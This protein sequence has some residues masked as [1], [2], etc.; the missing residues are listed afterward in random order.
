MTPETVL[1][2]V[3][4]FRRPAWAGEL[5]TA[6]GEQA[7][8]VQAGADPHGGAS[9]RVVVLDNDPDGSAREAVAEHPLVRSGAASYVHV[10]AKDVVSV[11]NAALDLARA[12]GVAVL[13]FIDDDEMPEPGWLAAFLRHRAE[14]G[15]DVIAGPVRQE[16]MV[17]EIPVAQALLQRAERARGPFTGD[18]GT[19]NV[20][21]SMDLVRRADLSFDS[22]TGRSGGE[23]TLFFRQAARAGARF[24]WEPKAAVIERSQPGRLTTRALLRR[25]YLNG[26]SSVLVDEALDGAPSRPRRLAT[27][28]AAA[29]VYLPLAAAR[30]VTGDRVAGWRLAHKVM[31][32]VGRAR[33]GRSSVGDYGG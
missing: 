26:R 32:H 12:E 21:I 3:P 33:A 4:T 6:L 18:V 10:G 31:R 8:S 13:V 16:P 22:I 29:G 2:A 9:V 14:L 30:A 7:S 23:D 27:A 28:V 20:L 15:A 11:R 19:G 24:S 25:S 5:L 17:A 1:V